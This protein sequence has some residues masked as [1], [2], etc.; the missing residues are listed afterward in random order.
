M[1]IAQWY[2]AEHNRAVAELAKNEALDAKRSAVQAQQ[3]A[4]RAA[5]QARESKKKQTRAKRELL[6]QVYVH[7]VNLADHALLAGDFEEMDS[8]LKD[9][10]KR[11]RQWG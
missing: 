3:L 10:S 8:Q 11:H 7:R 2:N 9:C 4:E 1:I 5:D 6:W